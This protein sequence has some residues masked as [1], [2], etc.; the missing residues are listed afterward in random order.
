MITFQKFVRNWRQSDVERVEMY[1]E[2]PEL[3]I[4][5]VIQYYRKCDTAVT[6]AKDDIDQ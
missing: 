3:R 5:S 1:R 6:R 2:D 4:D